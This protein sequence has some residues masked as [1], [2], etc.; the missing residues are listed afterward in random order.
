MMTAFRCTCALFL[1]LTLGSTSALVAQ[2]AAS[3]QARIRSVARELMIA[4]RYAA[5]ITVDSTG[6]TQ[7]RT[8]DPFAPDDA[9]V[10]W[11]AT[12]P[13]TRKVAE[14][15]RDSRVTLYYFS[16]QHGGYVTL[17]GRARLVDDPLEKQR[18]WKPEW[19]PFYPDRERDYLLVVVTPER[20]E[21]VSPGQG[22][23]GDS[24]TWRPPTVMVPPEHQE[25]Q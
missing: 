4:A 24:L 3:D 17:R 14:I 23:V 6:A 7:A 15:T 20:L 10:V 5:L 8:I 18:R 11:F 19:A 2:P 12:N 25:R 22:I 9:M 21:I 16:T 1:G 13:R